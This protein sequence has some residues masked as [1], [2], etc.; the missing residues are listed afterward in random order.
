M[1]ILP[2]K[3]DRIGKV[4]LGVVVT[5]LGMLGVWSCQLGQGSNVEDV[6]S[7]DKLYDSLAQYDSVVIVFKDGNGNF[8]DTVFKGKVQSHDELRNLPVPGWDGKKAQITISGF[9]G[10]ILVSQIEKKFNGASDE[11]DAT[12]VVVAP[13]TTLACEVRELTLPENDSLG[14]PVVTVTPATLN[15]KTLLWSS[16]DSTV[17]TVGPTS[18]KSH[19]RGT[20]SLVVHLRSDPSKSLTIPVTVIADNR[21]PDTLYLQPDTLRVAAEG[22]AG[23]LTVRVSPSSADAGVTWKVA[24]STVAT[25]TSDGA[26]QGLKAGQT[27]VWAVS[28]RKIG[29][30]DS[31]LV[32]VSAPVP[33]QKIRFVKNPVTLYV[34]GASDTLA[35]AVTPAEANPGVLFALADSSIVSVKDNKITGLSAGHTLIIAR[36][37]PYPGIVDTLQ[38]LVLA[39]HPVEKVVIADK[40]LGPVYMGGSPVRFFASVLPG[41]AP[42]QIQ[43]KIPNGS[44]ATIDDSGRVTGRTPGA[45]VVYAVSLAD[46]SKEDSAVIQVKRDMP[47]LNPGRDTVVSLGAT[48]A[49]TPTA[50]KQSGPIVQFKWDLD[51]DLVWDDSAADVKTVS[52]KYDQEKEY[53]VRFYVRDNQGND[54]TA[55]IKVKVVK[56]LVVLI[57]LPLNNSY[58]NKSPAKVFWSVNGQAQDTLPLETLKEGANVLTRTAKDSA[59]TPFS[60]SVTVNYDTT[61]PNKPLVHGTALVATTQPTWTW[62]TGGS[63][64]AGV[65]RY[66]L[67]ALTFANPETLD[68]LY[69]P[70]AALAAGPHTL[71]VQERDAA[72]NWSLSG[73]FSTT[74]DLTPPGTP[75][76]RVN[77][78][79]PTNNTKPT[80][81]WST[82]GGTGQFQSRLDIN[83]FSTMTTSAADTTFT[84]ATALTEGT[85]TLYVR[86]KGTAGNWSLVGSAGVTVDVTPP[87]APRISGTSPT[88]TNPKWNW[89]TGGGGSGD[90]RF[91]LGDANFPADAATVRDTT[92][93]L[94]P[95]PVSG[96]TYTLYVEERD[97]AG[98]WSLPVNLPIRY[99][100]TSPI[101]AIALPQAS[102]TFYTSAAS[103]TLSGTASGPVAI[104]Q[105][106]YKVGAA[107]AVK[108]TFTAGNW[109][110]P[111][112]PLTEGSST[113]ITVTA[114]DQAGNSGGALLTVLMDATAPGSPVLTSGPT[115]INVVKGDF[116]WT[117]G[118][119]GASGSGLNG[120]YRYSI[121]GGAWKDTT[122]TSLTN[123]PLIEGANLFS[124]QE[125]DRAQLWSAS[126]TRNLRVDTIGPVI[127]L[128]SHS[129]P[130]NSSSLT[131]TLSG[132]VKDTGT[133]VAAMTVSGQQSGSGTIT[134]TAGTWTSAALT[135]KSGANALLLTASDRVGNVHTLSLTV[136]VNIPA[137]VV[138]IT[139][140]ADS[141]TVT[142]FDTLY[143]SYTIDGG[144]VQTKLFSSLTEGVNRLVVS[145][146]ANA[147]GNIGRDTVKVTRDATPPSAPTVTRGTTPTKSSASWTLAANPDNNGG[148]GLRTPPNFQYSF[149]GGVSWTQ[150]TS[151]QVLQATEGTWTLIAQEQDK[152][153]NWSASSPGQ[154][155]VVDKTAPKVVITGPADKYVTS[156]SSVTIS[157]TIDGGPVQT[158]P[159]TLGA[160]NG[161]NTCTV[162][163]TDAAMNTGTATITVYRR[164]NVVFVTPTGAGNGSGA[165]W[166]N[167]MN[168]ANFST[169]VADVNYMGRDFWIGSG[170]INVDLYPAYSMSLY[171]GF[172]VT[173]T[174][175]DTT[176]R[177]LLGTRITG[178]FQATPDPSQTVMNFNMD[179]FVMEMFTA[180]GPGFTSILTN[181]KLDPQNFSNTYG[182]ELMFGTDVT[183][184]NLIITNT[185]FGTSAVKVNGTFH[186]VGGAITGNVTQYAD[187]LEDD[188]IMTMSNGATISGNIGSQPQYQGFGSGSL[189]IGSGVN[190]SCASMLMSGGTCSP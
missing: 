26:V 143:V 118:S 167:A 5:A 46:S 15:D 58:T 76:V 73:Q 50:K 74:I 140:P 180:S 158:T 19:A 147:S 40:S 119:D 21:I 176:G 41:D 36:S 116:A 157:Y 83:D 120:H 142:R 112:I 181:I 95:D 111:A 60:A 156:L 53:T 174:P 100:I 52:R 38:V 175:Y 47:Q 84:P 104:S 30:S 55:T 25:V 88:N 59:G 190:F 184:R 17:V 33:V 96:T 62:S 93:T 86:E 124:V 82:G 29:L 127:T 166:E 163:S 171:G 114:V 141:L 10:G 13:G 92:Y 89:T 18:L 188:G 137:P 117:P 14:I 81:T 129:N 24:D 145:S 94:V 101:V 160:T 34:G 85:H 153:G 39:G 48:V 128:T 165:N 121:N 130:A 57:Q 11:T 23:Q 31:S 80:W 64:G 106:N 135:L 152:A 12:I 72:G 67:D 150:T 110:T 8:L 170:I 45:A 161:A 183:T 172:D 2:I 42:Q 151:T 44:I 162:S 107:A 186:M 169:A 105:V 164:S 159:C 97:L 131:I 51:G 71:Y 134:V 61:A 125:Q 16:S 185:N 132:Q 66:S 9:N 122:A 102:G 126:A 108:A 28:K 54:T 22:T 49:F 69:T 115:E 146:P 149:D 56:G 75:R 189:T 98:N 133:A 70:A 91:R 187:A 7:F 138:V 155:I 1:R 87:A 3:S 178:Y 32:L 63:A 65:F 154:T 90:F 79:G 6:A 37:K 78:A 177:S 77:P 144:A 4:L 99:D 168:Q 43:W 123:L 173:K 136:N 27:W 179:G 20:A 139:N 113:P 148:A 35:V 182:M 68:T 109:T 103:I